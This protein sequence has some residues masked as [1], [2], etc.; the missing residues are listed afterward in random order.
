MP[1][2][3]KRSP[4]PAAS[5]EVDRVS[6]SV[7]EENCVNL[8]SCKW[9]A[10]LGTTLM[11]ALLAGCATT[12]A[13]EPVVEK[14]AEAPVDPKAQADFDAALTALQGGDDARAEQ[15]LLALSAN[16][17]ELSGPQANL[18]ILY[19]RSGKTDQAEAAFQRAVEINP[20]NSISLNY[21]GV[22]S[23]EQGKFKE[24]QGF[25]QRALQADPNYANAHRNYG[26]LL[27]LYLGK[28]PEALEHYKRYQE[29]TKGEDK[30][31]EKWVVDLSRRVK[32]K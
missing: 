30:E 3:K 8:S 24:A 14:A 21:L 31:V 6:E 28:L 17:P 29:L 18:G 16:Y 15:L 12:Q 26:I 25:Y 9:R 13:P 20:K 23:R 32:A 5:I 22:I 1:R 19:Y 4:S 11:V 7:K 10:W 2:L 27:E